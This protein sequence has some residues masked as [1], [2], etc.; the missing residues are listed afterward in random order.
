MAWIG[1][2]PIWLPGG[3][4]ILSGLGWWQAASRARALNQR[5]AHL[6]GELDLLKGQLAHLEEIASHDRLTGAWNRRQFEA[7]SEAEAN[8]ARRRRSPL[9]L[10]LLDLDHFKRIND[11]DGHPAGN[12]V[13]AGAAAAFRAAL[14]TSDSLYRWGGEEFVVLSPATPLDG[15]VRLAERIR[16]ALEAASFPSAEPMTLSAGVAEYLADEPREEW[17]SR[18]DQA[19]YRAKEAGR[20]QVQADPT[21]SPQGTFQS[22]GLLELV[23]EDTYGSGHRLID[24]Q[25]MRLFTLANA[26]LSAAL[27]GQAPAVTEGRV[28]ELLFHTEKHFRDEEALLAK[29]GYPDL[30]QHRTEHA[31]LLDDARRL[32]VDMKAGHVDFGRLVAYLATDLVRGHLLSEDCNYFSHLNQSLGR[33]SRA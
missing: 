33:E 9:S 16:R 24:D 21:R 8:L 6:A 26:V 10:I 15:A 25:H 5:A 22:P 2:V 28:D 11:T 7:A 18:A 23:W 32:Q 4:A 29:A 30:P 20:N 12:T 27:E 17:I 31:R 13:L 1:L 3:V 19:L 14:R